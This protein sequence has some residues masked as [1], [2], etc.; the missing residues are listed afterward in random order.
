MAHAQK[1]DF[2]FRRN[3]WVHLNQRGRQ[4]SR[5]LAV[6]VCASAV[7]MLN[8]PCSEVVWR[9][10][11]THSIRQFPLHFP[12]RASS[13]AVT[14]QLDSTTAHAFSLASQRVVSRETPRQSVWYFWGQW[15]KH[16]PPLQTLRFSTVSTIPSLFHNHSPIYLLRYLISGNYNAFKWLTKTVT[17]LRSFLTVSLHEC[18]H[19]H[20]SSTDV[21][22][23]QQTD[24]VFKENTF[25]CPVFARG[26]HS[27]ISTQP[28]RPGL[29][30]TRAQSCDWYGSGTLH[31][32]Q[33]L[34]GSL[35]HCFHP[36]LDVPTLAAR[37]LRPQRRERS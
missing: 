5:L 24:S 23:S 13:C 20:S 22:H 11:A 18:Y 8:T 35:C 36:P 9:V 3:G 10:L 19:T 17:V 33:V 14:F 28:W 16:S 30:G 15:G 25:C 1:P 34:G 2:V 29:A 31:P 37:C 12:T 26:I 21:I 7:V 32:G 4:F 27:F 6:E